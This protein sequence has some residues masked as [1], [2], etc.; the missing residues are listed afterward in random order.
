MQTKIKFDFFN[1][2]YL[3]LNKQDIINVYF[4]YST[5]LWKVT[6]ILWWF[7]T[8]GFGQTSYSDISLYCLWSGGKTWSWQKVEGGEKTGFPAAGEK[9][10]H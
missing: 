4:Y 2:N 3:T 8:N 9:N 5:K 6:E 7:W 1:L 10:T